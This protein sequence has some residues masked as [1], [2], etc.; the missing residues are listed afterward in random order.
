MMFM[1][2]KLL[3]IFLIFAILIVAAL[4]F[5]AWSWNFTTSRINASIQSF[6]VHQSPTE[7]M[8]NGIDEGYVGIQEARITMAVPETGPGG[9]PYIWFVTV[10]IW[11]D[12]RADGSSVGSATNDFDFGGSYYLQTKSGWILMPETSAPLFVAFWMR[13]FDLEGEGIAG[14]IIKE[15]ATKPVCV[16]NYS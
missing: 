15:P 5:T 11:A 2:S 1:R 10:C 7:A 12:S 13:V 6:G 3:R 16:R 4:V 8:L 9:A 14:P